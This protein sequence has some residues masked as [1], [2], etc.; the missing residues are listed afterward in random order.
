MTTWPDDELEPRAGA[1][2]VWAQAADWLAE[3]TSGDWTSDKQA[4]LD[5]WLAESSGNLLAYWR[6]EAAWE[7]THRLAALRV[8]L[9]ESGRPPP[10]SAR[11]TIIKVAAVVAAISTL[12]GLGA[13]YSSKPVG[14]IFTTTTGGHEIVTLAD[15]SSIELNTNTQLRLAEGVGRS[16]TLDRGEAYFQIKHDV[17]HPF[18]VVAGDHRVT[19]LG[20]KF[21]VR[22]DTAQL[23]VSLLEGSARVDGIGSQSNTA[24][25]TLTPGDVAIAAGESL[26]ITK[27]PERRLKNDL[28]WRHG[29]LVFDNTSIGDVVSELNRY[30]KI[31]LIVADGATAKIGIGGTFPARDTRAFIRVAHEL[32]GLQVASRG[33]EL[34]ISR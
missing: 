17:A 15:G 3:R 4:G 34:I 10:K 26:A 30:N 8:P 7:R 11:P 25:A 5:T 12:A 1:E 6:L 13:F 16:V 28:A 14:K 20:T 33:N 9:K 23:K 19:D 32:L 27:K 21:V 24:S 18:V 29:L 31:K 2:A 22:R